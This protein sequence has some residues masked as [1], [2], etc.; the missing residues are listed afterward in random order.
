[1][2]LL[3]E[4]GVENTTAYER[5][6]ALLAHAT[7]MLYMLVPVEL[8]LLNLLGPLIVW[9]WKG[10]ETEFIR[11][12]AARSV[13]FQILIA[14]FHWIAIEINSG[15]WI[16]TGKGG[17]FAVYMVVGFHILMTICASLL[18]MEGRYFRYLI[19]TRLLRE[20]PRGT[21]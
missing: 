18:A 1:M 21:N 8:P 9:G 12:N 2:S 4:P 10:R 6:W 13:N 19:T 14:I 3:V 11:I 17:I 16:E 20:R 15:R 5:K 7:S